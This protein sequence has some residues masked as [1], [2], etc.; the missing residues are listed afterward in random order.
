MVWLTF[1]V[2]MNLNTTVSTVRKSSKSM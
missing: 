1:Q 2:A